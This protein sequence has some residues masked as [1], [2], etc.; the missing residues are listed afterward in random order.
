M[1][2]IATFT[3]LLS[4]LFPFHPASYVM[5]YHTIMSNSSAYINGLR[6]ARRLADT[7]SNYT[8]VDIFPYAVWYVYY[9]QYLSTTHDMAL[10][11]GV[12]VGMCSKSDVVGGVVCLVKGHLMSFC[13]W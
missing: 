1:V 3:H 8:G 2:E 10:N 4:S 5:T 12:S 6:W 11:I 7:L 9:E 13:F